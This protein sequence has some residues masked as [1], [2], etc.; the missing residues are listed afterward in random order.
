MWRI[1]LS[2]I[3]GVII[4]IAYMVILSFGEGYISESFVETRF[5][6]QPAPGVL[7][8][9]VTIPVYFDILVKEERILP[10]IFD[11]FWFRFLSFILFNWILYGTI[12]YLLLG[13]FKR[14]KRKSVPASEAPPPPP[15]F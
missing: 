5:Y 10:M 14:F 2:I 7:L 15:T 3:L 11:T 9:P 13:C 4:P 12:S 6:S 1:I 8:A